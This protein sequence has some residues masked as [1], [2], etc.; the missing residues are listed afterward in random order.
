MS[1]NEVRKIIDKLSKLRALSRARERVRQ[2]ERE[3]YGDSSRSEQPGAVPEF[4]SQRGP[5]RAV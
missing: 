5:L 1:D 3:L 4:L 2:L